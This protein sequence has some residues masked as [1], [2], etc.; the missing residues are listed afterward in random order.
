MNWIGLR[1]AD[2]LQR[3]IRPT[4]G[5]DNPR[6]PCGSLIIELS[7]QALR[8]GFVDL[9]RFRDADTGTRRIGVRLALDGHLIV[10]LQDGAQKA[11]ADVALPPVE[12]A[13]TL[14]L[15]IAWD[16]ARGDG[17]AAVGLPEEDAWYDAPLRLPFAPLRADLAAIVAHEDHAR[18][19]PNID[20]VAVS[21]IRE[22]IGI[23]PGLAEGTR[24]ETARGPVR[25][26]HIERGDLVRTAENGFQPVRARVAR[27]IPT[28][29][30][31]APILLSPPALG[32][33]S[34]L[35]VSPDHHLLIESAESEYLF[36]HHAVLLCA[37]RLT[38]LSLG[39][40]IIV[41]RTISF[42]QLIFDRH[43]IIRTG[44]CWSESLFTGGFGGRGR[45]T[46]NTVLDPRRIGHVPIHTER[47]HPRLRDYEATVLVA[48]MCA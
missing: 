25:I 28:H 5:A 39:R 33:T 8:G 22:P 32:L 43:E 21:C 1:T 19:H 37:D 31:C 15:T 30:W 34:S 7:T 24:V 29:G 48:E 18:L 10:E 4:D 44:G 38:G 40:P 6:L 26:D 11:I 20:L 12:T 2:D 41:S 23:L 13:S 9:V 3:R 35:L 17:Y 36:G 16:V 42:H 47:A 14:R 46:R 45:L 27:S